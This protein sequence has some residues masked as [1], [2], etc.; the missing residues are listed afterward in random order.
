MPC[1][2]VTN[3]SPSQAVVALTDERQL[4]GCATG[5]ANDCRQGNWGRNDGESTSTTARKGGDLVHR[6]AELFKLLMRAAARDRLSLVAGEFHPRLS[7]SAP[8][9][10]PYAEQEPGGNL[11]YYWL[12]SFCSL[13]EN[14]RPRWPEKIYSSSFSLAWLRRKDICRT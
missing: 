6:G 14:L 1:P 9:D 10:I 13:S 3:E 5:G 7:T 11:R 2:P 8:G 12:P 4:C